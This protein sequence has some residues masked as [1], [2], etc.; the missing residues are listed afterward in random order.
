MH[1]EDTKLPAGA[2]V[3]MGN[4]PDRHAKITWILGTKLIGSVDVHI[5]YSNPNYFFLE[6]ARELRIF[7]LIEEAKTQKL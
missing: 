5:D 4:S 6:Y 2:S 7:I 3:R 1:A